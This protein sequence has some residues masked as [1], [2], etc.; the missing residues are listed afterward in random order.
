MV[1]RELLILPEIARRY[2]RPL[3]TIRTAWVTDPAWPQPCGKRG[4]YNEYDAAEVG[5]AVAA[6]TG[7]PQLDGDPDELLTIAQAAEA[8]GLAEATI[9]AD[10]SR[11]RWPNPDDDEHGVKRWKRSTVASVRLGRRK[12]KRRT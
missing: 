11:G 9:R 5:A 6:I 8:T 3:S 1:T 4:R 2:E 12:Y 7:R 10:L